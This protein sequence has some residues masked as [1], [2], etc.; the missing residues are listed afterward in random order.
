MVDLGFVVLIV[1]YF[2]FPTLCMDDAVLAL[3]GIN[4]FVQF[5]EVALQHDF[6]IE[7]WLYTPEAH[8]ATVLMLGAPS[9]SPIRITINKDDGEQYYLRYSWVL[10]GISSA[11]S[12]VEPLP[13]GRW[14]HI[15]IS[16]APNRANLYVNGFLNNYR[17]CEQPLRNMTRKTNYL[18]KGINGPERANFFGM[19]DDVRLWEA[20]RTKK[21]IV[22][23][24]RGM[25]SSDGLL[26]AYSMDYAAPG[27]LIANPSGEM[28]EHGQVNC[29][30]AACSIY[31]THPKVICGD[32]VRGP[33]EGCDDGN[34]VSGDGCSNGCMVEH[35]YFCTGGED[36]KSIDVCAPGTV[37]VNE[38]FES[39][40]SLSGWTIHSPHGSFEVNPRYRKGGELGLRMHHRRGP[41]PG[42][43][44]L[45]GTNLNFR[46]GKDFDGFVGSR[47]SASVVFWNGADLLEGSKYVLSLG[48]PFQQNSTSYW[49][50]TDGD[51]AARQSVTSIN[52]MAKIFISAEFTGSLQFLIIEF[53][54]EAGAVL[55]AIANPS[56]SFPE[57]RNQ[58]T[59][60]S[61]EIAGIPPDTSTIMFKIGELQ[62]V[63]SGSIFIGYLSAVPSCPGLPLGLATWLKGEYGVVV[64][65]NRVIRWKDL[66]G[67]ENDAYASEEDRKPSWV[68]HS[69]IGKFPC[70]EFPPHTGLL[71]EDTVSVNR[72][73]T[74]FI[75]QR[76]VP[77]KDTQKGC[78]VQGR[79][80]RRFCLGQWD[81]RR[82]Q[83][84]HNRG[85][86]S[87]VSP[88]NWAIEA[89]V[90][91]A[92][93]NAFRVNGILEGETI[94]EYQPANIAFGQEGRHSWNGYG[95]IAELLIYKRVLT[96]DEILHV[97]AYLAEKYDLSSTSQPS[98]MPTIIAESHDIIA[99]R[100]LEAASTAPHQE[101]LFSTRMEKE[102][103]DVV[104]T[105]H[106]LLSLSFS[107][108]EAPLMWGTPL[109]ITLR[110]A[111]S[112]LAW[113]D[114]CT[115]RNLGCPKG[116]LVVRICVNSRSPDFCD[117][118]IESPMGRWQSRVF[119]VSTL[120]SSKYD[121]ADLF[122]RVLRL[123][124]L[125]L[126]P[127]QDSQILLDDLKFIDISPAEECSQ[128][129]VQAIAPPQVS[130]TLSH[131]SDW[132]IGT[133]L[134][135]KFTW[136]DTQLTI[137]DYSEAEASRISFTSKSVFPSSRQLSYLLEVSVMSGEGKLQLAVCG[138]DV[139]LTSDA[140]KTHWVYSSHHE[141]S[142]RMPVPDIVLT[143][144]S[145]HLQHFMSMLREY[146]SE[147]PLPEAESMSFSVWLKPTNVSM[148]LFASLVLP[149][150][151][152]AS[153]DTYWAPRYLPPKAREN[154][155]C[156]Q[157]YGVHKITRNFSEGCKT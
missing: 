3:D 155:T 138:E 75:V 102:F 100:V 25:E 84:V 96:E 82:E 105:K 88:Y 18:G 50:Q 95:Q 35:E 73:S 15:A 20:S 149:G 107:I 71:F 8:T 74:V 93:G 60:V 135:H 34:R 83:R 39:T 11:V 23:G 16:Q 6:T 120:F 19:I 64:E 37:L 80:W 28:E 124:L 133:D 7:F 2:I 115:L 129:R 139:W 79:N 44:E 121:D 45:L 52:V 126:S 68:P 54:D 140:T 22:K 143:H 65:E 147:P 9:E 24:L 41:R 13:C 148:K 146:Y 53:V 32:G 30:S 47:G 55:K 109:I 157:T 33:E 119:S 51:K 134:E 130:A 92:N 118:Q 26:L 101:L 17:D 90:F 27:K 78:L 56:E 145:T 113:N 110:S 21:D 111:E 123:G 10:D 87:E 94:E 142:S 141:L 125:S 154:G 63:H 49:I 58:W 104:I 46:G 151:H 99:T 66:S 150:S 57:T 103:P 131:P 4:D 91:S 122:P 153:P 42:C 70:L 144:P 81:K 43:E 132:D 31:L 36:L 97:E 14:V 112:H 116:E 29:P 72:P 106:T 76:L 117:E 136:D 77:G 61:F 69:C 127:G 67:L 1:L 62:E 89:H 12:T 40:D 5:P 85:I 108:V 86:V 98:G 152:A 114:L 48:G 156:R 128:Y 38:G 59:S 137:Q